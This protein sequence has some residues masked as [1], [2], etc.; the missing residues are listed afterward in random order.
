MF[1][2][3]KDKDEI[4][5]GAY[6]TM[7]TKGEVI[8]QFFVDKDDAICYNVQLEALGENLFVTETQNENIDRLCQVLGY[9]YT[10]IQPG[11]VVVP[12]LETLANEFL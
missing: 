3:T 4:Q 12:R 9:A 6:A 2:L 11:E 5:S 10:I 7:N 1:L 8:V